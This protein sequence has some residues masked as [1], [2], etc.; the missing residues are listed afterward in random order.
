MCVGKWNLE[1]LLLLKAALEGL[2]GTGEIAQSIKVDIMSSEYKIFERFSR[3]TEENYFV[4][5][6]SS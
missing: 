2:K 3:Q 1:A 6:N 4:Y 5:K